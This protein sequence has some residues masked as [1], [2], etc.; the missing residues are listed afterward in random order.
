MIV[1]T[2]RHSIDSKGMINMFETWKVLPTNERYKVSNFGRVLDRKDDTILKPFFEDYYLMVT[3]MEKVSEQPKIERITPRY[4][5][6]L[7]ADTFLGRKNPN[8][9]VIFKNNK[10]HMPWASNLKLVK[11]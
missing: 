4:V 1:L 3:V 7:V 5:H 11:D 10:H 6:N 2:L 9:V 8:E